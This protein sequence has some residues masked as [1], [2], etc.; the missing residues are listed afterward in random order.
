MA[1]E[2]VTKVLEE[3]ADMNDNVPRFIG[4]CKWFSD[5]HGYGFLTICSGDKKGTDIFAHH[6]SITPKNSSYKTL[7]K[8]EYV[9]FSIVE[10]AN[11]LQADRIT[12]ISNGPLMCD[13]VTSKR[14]YIQDGA[15][16]QDGGNDWQHVPSSRKPQQ[17]GYKKRY[18]KPRNVADNV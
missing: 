12:G 6:T 2:V 17:N 14:P 10:G 7:R 1:Q 4:Q 15:R 13:F 9:E 16:Q 11:G 3:I 8:G 5:K 18:N